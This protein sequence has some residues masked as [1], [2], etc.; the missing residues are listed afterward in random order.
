[1]KD[2]KCKEC[3]DKVVSRGYCRK[4]YEKAKRNNVFEVKQHGSCRAYDIGTNDMPRG[5]RKDNIRQYKLWYAMME[6]CYSKKWL[7]SHKTYIDCHVCERWLTLS[8]FIEDLPSVEGYEYWIT[9]PNKRI[10][11]DKDL[12]SKNNKLYSLENCKFIEC[13]ENAKDGQFRNNRNR[14]VVRIFND[15]S[16]KIYEST[17]APQHEDGFRQTSVSN[18]CRGK[19]KFHKGYKWMFLDEF[20]K[21]QQ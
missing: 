13:S 6:R 21:M 14:Q 15:G 4:H 2:K 3:D 17:I 12:K 1:M 16:I 19:Q 11:L 20:E 9:N 5:W 10:A 7:K 18:C 8:N